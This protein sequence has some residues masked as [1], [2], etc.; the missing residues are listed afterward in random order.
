MNTKGRTKSDENKHNKSTAE[1]KRYNAAKQRQKS[2]N[3]RKR[4]VEM[5]KKIN[6]RVL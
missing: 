5:S 1:R 3:R 6:Q 2:R 4:S